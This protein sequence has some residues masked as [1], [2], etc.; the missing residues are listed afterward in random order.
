[1]KTT[2]SQRRT[3]LAIGLFI[4]LAA[5]L[6][7]TFACLPAPVGDPEQAKLDDTL[8]GAW[9]LV[10]SD[11]SKDVGVVLVRPMDSHTYFAQY[12]YLEVKDDKSEKATVLNYRAW[13]TTLGG[14]TFITCESLD[15]SKFIDPASDTRYYWV[16]KL[17]RKGDTVTTLPVNPDLPIVK[18]AK[19]REQMEAVVKA[20]LDRKEFYSSN[21]VFKK[22]DK[23]QLT[24]VKELRAKAH[25]G[26]ESAR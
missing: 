11:A 14:A 5:I 25:L 21:I 17:D 3:L 1:M 23:G 12:I 18:E 15:D 6:L 7:A 2:T 19:T 20:N 8:T 26:I 9:Q 10:P 22:L 13:L 16:A 4:P 24:L